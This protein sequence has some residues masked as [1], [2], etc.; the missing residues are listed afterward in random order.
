YLNVPPAFEI[1]FSLPYHGF[2]FK[3]FII[4]E[5]IGYRHEIVLFVVDQTPVSACKLILCYL[6]GTSD[7]FVIADHL[8]HWFVYKFSADRRVL[9][10]SPVDYLIDV[11]L[12]V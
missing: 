3:I 1:G 10:R 6:K 12:D 9:D 7:P 2:I 4:I 11:I 8:N 5:R